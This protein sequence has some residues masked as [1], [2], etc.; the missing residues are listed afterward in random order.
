MSVKNVLQENIAT[1]R[2]WILQLV[3]VGMDIIV[4][5]GQRVQP[6]TLSV[7]W[8]TSVKTQLSLE[9]E[10]LNNVHKESSQKAFRRHHV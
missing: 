6:R 1:K 2:A 5:K 9:Q 10:N 7:L 8:D 3:I 4:L